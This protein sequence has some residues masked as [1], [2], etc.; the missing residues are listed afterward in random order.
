MFIDTDQPGDRSGP[1][2]L[3]YRP[4]QKPF[5]PLSMMKPL[6]P[7]RLNPFALLLLPVV[8]TGILTPPGFAAEPAGRDTAADRALLNTIHSDE[9]K[10]IMRRLDMLAYENEYTELE[11]QSMRVSQLNHL[12]EFADELVTTADNLPQITSEQLSEADR[13]TFK[14]MA[15]QLYTD[16]LR[17]K[18]DAA[19]RNYS[20]MSA[21][22][23]GLRRT[24]DS[25]HRLFRET[26]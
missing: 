2:P 6:I 4:V 24:C 22:Y 18:A 17:L 14:A 1:L 11:I 7:A 23:Q 20:D 3:E 16:T 9:L 13:I 26:R 12:L 10:K 5:M 8:L 19:E 15:R 25:C 21:R